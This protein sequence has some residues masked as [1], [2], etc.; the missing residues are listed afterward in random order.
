MGNALRFTSSILRW[1]TPVVRP[2]SGSLSISSSPPRASTKMAVCSPQVTSPCYT[3][4]CSCSTMLNCKAGPSG[5]G[6]PS[7]NRI[8]RPDP[9]TCK[10][11][12]IQ[13]VS[14]I[15]GSA[16]SASPRLVTMSLSPR[17]TTRAN[18]IR[19]VSAKKS[20]PCRSDE[21]CSEPAFKKWE[22]RIR[23]A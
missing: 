23:A 11:M 18:P 17:T 8:P 6:P 16:R 15:S 13:S 1:S 12:A 20:L 3:T 2:E 4:G 21:I 5:I 9:F 7:T 22:S 19:E 10:T 14:A